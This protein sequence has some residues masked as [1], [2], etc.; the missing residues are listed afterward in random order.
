MNPYKPQSVIPVFSTLFLVGLVM[1]GCQ[2]ISHSP[3]VSS[4]NNSSLEKYSNSVVIGKTEYVDLPDLGLKHV[5]MKVDTGA[6]T[7]TMHAFDINELERD[8][9]KFVSFKINP[10]R[11]NKQIEQFEVKLFDKR[12][13][14]GT[15]GKAI[16]RPV[17]RSTIKLGDQVRVVEFTLSD[18]SKMQYRFLLGREA[19][20]D[21]VLVNPGAEFLL[22]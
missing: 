19:L 4:L 22:R 7:S 21:N 17:I 20:K 14:K 18:R 5:E 2:T 8:G 16:M 9:E 6:Q 10:Y 1:L 11:E 13:V 3:S 15:C 12:K